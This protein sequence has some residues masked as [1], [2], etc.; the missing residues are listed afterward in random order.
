M[1][2]GGHLIDAVSPARFDITFYCRVIPGVFHIPELTG[3]LHMRFGVSQAPLTQIIGHWQ[4]KA[5]NPR[6]IVVPVLK[7]P[8]NQRRFFLA[9]SLVGVF[10][11]LFLSLHQNLIEFAEELLHIVKVKFFL[12]SFQRLIA[13]MDSSLNVRFQICGPL[14]SQPVRNFLK[15]PQQV[16]VTLNV[17]NESLLAQCWFIAY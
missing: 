3:D 14:P 5:R 8:A 13:V 1:D 16:R 12:S 2:E 10:L 15:V 6:E 7:E 11:M 17:L 4:F 9:V